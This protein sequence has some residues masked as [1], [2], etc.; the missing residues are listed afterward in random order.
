VCDA[1]KAELT[2]KFI[3]LNV[4]IREERIK[5]NDRVLPQNIEN[6]AGC[7]GSCLYSYLFGTQNSR[8]AWA[9]SSRDHKRWMWWCTC[10]PPGD[11]GPGI[12]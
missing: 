7:D 5:V 8:P 1:A 2:G 10:H 12:A 3:A 6:E 4:Y 11:P 9:K